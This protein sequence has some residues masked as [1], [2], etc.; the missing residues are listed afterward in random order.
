MLR[1]IVCFQW[2][3]GTPDE[4]VQAVVD[5]LLA[6]PDVIP[7]IRRYDLG[8]DAGLSDTTHD[9]ALIAEF[10]TED[11]FRTY[12]SHPEHRRVVDERIT[13]ILESI[14]RVQTVE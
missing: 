12:V 1:H 11:D 14:V 6:L 7:E 3:T 8:H 10:D 13:P 9:M 5:G 4:S 2:R